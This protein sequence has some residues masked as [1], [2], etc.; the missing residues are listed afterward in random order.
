METLSSHSNKSA[1]KTAINRTFVTFLTL[2]LRTLQKSFF[3]PTY[4]VLNI[5]PNFSILVAMAT[6]QM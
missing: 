4:S 3:Y 1:V 2:M 6:N 5:S